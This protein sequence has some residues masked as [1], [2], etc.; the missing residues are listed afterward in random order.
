MRVIA[1]LCFT[2]LLTACDGG[3]PT[4]IPGSEEDTRPYSGIGEG[5]TVRFTGNEPFWGGEVAGGML[6]YA[7]PENSGGEAI[8]VERFAGRNGVSWSGS[9]DG[10]PFTLA[11]TPGECSD[12]MSDRSYPFVAMVSIG[13]EDREGCAWTDARPFTGPAGP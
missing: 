13:G 12:G 4:N 9:L 6:T 10:A 2:L 1:S 7:T 8:P 11:V 5:E 3:E